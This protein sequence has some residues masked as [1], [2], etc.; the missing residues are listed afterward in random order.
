[1]KLLPWNWIVALTILPTLGFGG[2]DHDQ[3]AELKVGFAQVDIT[4]PVGAIM[5]G[6][7]FPLAIATEDPL[8]AKA[9]LA[10]SGPRTL[11][12]VSVDLVKIRRDLADAAI[13]EVHERTG[14]DPDA[15][16]ICPPHN[17]SSPFVPRGGPNNQKYLSTLPGL[18]AESIEQAHERLRHARMLLG[19]SLVYEG[20]NNRRVIS[21]ADD[22]ALNTRLTKLDDRHQETLSV[23][24]HDR[25]RAD[26]RLDWL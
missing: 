5:T 21:K 13:A 18:I 3:S 15:V 2:Q 12:I 22:M 17:H 1:M 9:M 24:P 6:P 4:P 20:V 14:I 10:E 19:R 25:M 23:S 26:E 16:L 8:Y 11:A 7:A